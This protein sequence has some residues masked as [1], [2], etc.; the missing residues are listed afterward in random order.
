LVWLAR[1]FFFFYGTYGTLSYSENVVLGGIKLRRDF[2]VF[3]NR[4]Y[5]H[6]IQHKI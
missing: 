1:H 4:R 5:N 3:R 2:S 6:S